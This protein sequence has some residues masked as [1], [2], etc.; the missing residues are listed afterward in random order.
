MTR[1]F[2]YAFTFIGDGN[3]T[4]YSSYVNYDKEKG[5]S[6]KYMIGNIVYNKQGELVTDQ[7][8]LSSKPTFFSVLPGK[9]GYVLI[10]EYFRKKK[11]LV[12]RL[13]KMDV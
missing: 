1:G 12:V 5:E 13:E 2:D 8:P 10:F 11:E 7:I 3:K 4:F 9:P 6:S